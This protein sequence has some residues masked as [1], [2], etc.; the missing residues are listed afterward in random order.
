[1][2][3][4][5]EQFQ[6][7]LRVADHS[8]L[9]QADFHFVGSDDSTAVEAFLK[10]DADAI[11]RVRALG[12]PLFQRLVEIGNVRFLPIDHAAAMRIR[13][14]AF[15]PALIPQGA[16]QGE[17]PVPGQDLPSVAVHRTLLANA[18]TDEGVVRIITSVLLERR[19]EMMAEIPASTPEVRLLLAQV[20]KPDQQVGL[21]PALHRGA[22]SLYD[23][24]KP[25]FLLAHADYVG[26]MVTVSLMIGSWL[27]ELKQW[28]QRQQK[29]KADAYSRQ[30]LALMSASQQT[31]STVRL[32]EIRSEL[33]GVLAAVFA[34]LDADRLSEE[35]FHSFRAIL[36]IA[37]DVVKDKRT[38]AGAAALVAVS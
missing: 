9:P 16:Y 29:N 12:N 17:P 31:D 18:A 34:D 27:W 25:S 36:Q 4:T 23:K 2:P 6:S 26:L 10:G 22:A 7:F 21:V 8:G 19:Q 37:L 1:M 24:D 20:R 3:Q 15:E 33:L 28:M 38:S 35:S 13:Q 14:P 5:G 32:D 11:F 30:V